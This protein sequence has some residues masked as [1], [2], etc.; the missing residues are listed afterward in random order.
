M[1]KVRERLKEHGLELVLTDEA[2]E[3]DRQEGLETSNS[4]PG[5]CAG[6]SR[7]CV[8]DPLS[9]ELLKGEF[10][11]KDTITVEVME[12]GGKKQLKFHGSLQHAPEPAAATVGAGSGPAAAPTV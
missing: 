12:V 8:E 10:Q 2:K 11:G 3:L 4:A 7:T 1:Q 5:R 6:R 9:E